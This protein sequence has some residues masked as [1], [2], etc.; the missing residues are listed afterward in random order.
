MQRKQVD[1]EL[2]QRY[3]D[4]ACSPAEMR[5]VRQYLQG[6]DHRESLEDFMAA[7][8]QQ[9]AAGM[10][11]PATQADYERFLR[12]TGTPVRKV[13]VLRR[14]WW[15]AAAAVL[16]A[17]ASVAWWQ[18]Q[19]TR[20]LLATNQILQAPAGKT[21]LIHLPDSSLIYLGPGSSLTY[22]K[23]YN[24]NNRDLYL[25]GEAYFVVAHGGRHPFS[26]H[27]GKLTTVDIGTA[28]NIRHMPGGSGTDV[29]VAEGK[30]AVH[31]QQQEIPLQKE[32]RLHFETATGLLSKETVRPGEA[33]GG[34]RQGI[35]V[36]RH[37]T[38]K[39]IMADLERQY[40]TVI[41][42]TSPEM[43]EISITTT[44][45]GVSLDT[46]LDIICETAGVH[47]IQQNKVIYIK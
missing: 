1:R 10:E 6:E 28:F 38:L 7:D 11:P 25:N 19:H 37:M 22:N 13:G 43:E 5:E 47:Y 20:A 41:R 2:L 17:V 35:L 12:L 44:L 34:W 21:T 4:G 14:M 46:A 16:I 18:Q 36:F 24:I 30:V 9:I 31:Y 26:V 45:P 27:T 39:E 42:F 3:L 15:A 33:I 40:G 8:W 29:T 32:E 23:G